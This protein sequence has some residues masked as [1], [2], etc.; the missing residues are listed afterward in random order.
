MKRQKR[1]LKENESSSS[2]E[3]DRIKKLETMMESLLEERAKDKEKIKELEEE[4]RSR[5]GSQGTAEEES[6]ATAEEQTPAAEKRRSQEH[7]IHTCR[8]LARSM[9]EVSQKEK[10]ERI[11]LR[12]KETGLQ[13]TV[14][15][16]PNTSGSGT[17][18]RSTGTG[19]EELAKDGPKDQRTEQESRSARHRKDERRLVGKYQRKR[20]GRRRKDQRKRKE[21]RR[22]EQRKRK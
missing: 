13:S 6:A 19:S 1:Q 2:Q 20:K 9:K 17:R 22:K 12:T 7:R 21:G 16:E 5:T 14:F 11:V 10:E 4:V 18:K 3:D 15:K 8:Q